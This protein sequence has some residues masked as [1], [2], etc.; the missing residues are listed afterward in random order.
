MFFNFFIPDDVM[1]PEAYLGGPLGHGSPL[2]KKNFLTYSKNWKTWF[3]PLCV[4]TSGQRKF[5]PPLFE[6]LNTPL[7]EA[8]YLCYMYAVIWL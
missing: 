5:A 6:I 7:N 2:A 1:K 3:L 8:A 4:S